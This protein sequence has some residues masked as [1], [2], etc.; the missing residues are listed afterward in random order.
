M[1]TTLHFIIEQLS[2]DNISEVISS[3][4]YRHGD[5]TSVLSYNPDNALAQ[6]MKYDKKFF[7]KLEEVPIGLPNDVIQK[8][9]S[10]ELMYGD[11]RTCS[12]WDFAEM[13]RDFTD[14]PNNVYNV[15][16][17]VYSDVGYE[18][19]KNVVPFKNP[20]FDPPKPSVLTTPSVQYRVC[21]WLV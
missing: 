13:K 17:S 1:F 12:L 6:F 4:T 5:I 19:P 11:G 20:R 21:F 3:N 14:T 9:L 7:A 8:V 2:K 15:V 16:M 10:F 18:L